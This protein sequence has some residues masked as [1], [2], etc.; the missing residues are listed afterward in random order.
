MKL[1]KSITILFLVIF[2]SQPGIAQVPQAI[3]YQAVARD[4]DGNLIGN[5]TVSLRF[6]VH[7]SIPSGVVVYQEIQTLNTNEFGLFTARIGEGSVITGDFTTIEWGL[8]FK[9]LQVELDT[10]GGSNFTDMGTNQMLSVPYA[11]YANRSRFADSSSFN[12]ILYDKDFMII[13]TSSHDT[14]FRVDTTGV[15]KHKGK[16]FFF[17]G[18]WVFDTLTVVDSVGNP[19]FIIHPDG[20]SWHKGLETFRGGTVTGDSTGSLVQIKPDG[21]IEMRDT[22]GK[23]L[24]R[25]N[26]DGTSFHAGFETFAGGA[27]YGDSTGALVRIKPDGTIE[28]LDTTGNV[29]FKINP[30]GTSY[31]AGLETFAGGASYG[32][33]TG[34][35]VQIKPDGTIEMLDSTGNVLFKVNPDGTSYHAG[36]ETFASGIVVGDT[37]SSF[38]ILLPDGTIAIVD[39]AGNPVFGVGP[40]GSSFHYGIEQF[41]GGI[42]VGESFGTN[43]YLNPDGSIEHIAGNGEL[44][45]K[46]DSAGN[47]FH[48][49]HEIFKGGISVGDTAAQH[50]RIQPDGTIQILDS[51]KVVIHEINPNGTVSGSNNFSDGIIVGDSSSSHLIVQPDG[52]IQLVDS[53]GTVMFKVNPDGTSY[54]DGL[55]S[56][57]SGIAVGDSGYSK[58]RAYSDGS[59]AIVDTNGVPVFWTDGAGN[60]YHKGVEFFETKIIVGASNGEIILEPD[61]FVVRDSAGSIKII[62]NELGDASFDGDVRIEGNTFFGSPDSSFTLIDKYGSI[63]TYDANG[64]LVFRVKPDGTS[65]HKGL[66]TFEGGISVGDPSG[67][68][69]HLNPD[70]GI[71]INDAFNNPVFSVD[72]AGNS[73]HK[74]VEQFDSEIII[75]AAGGKRLRL[76]PGYLFGQDASGTTKFALDEYGGYIEGDLDVGGYS[77]FGAGVSS[78]NISPDGTLSVTDS[79]GNVTFYVLPD[80]S[81]YHKGTELF[82]KEII[83][84]SAGGDKLILRPGIIIG[85]DA[86]GM[87][88]YGIDNL[89]GASFDGDL[90]VFGWS[91]FGGENGTTEIGPDGRIAVYD[92]LG[93]LV[94]QVLPDGSSFHKGLEIFETGITVLPTG[95]ISG[96]GSGIFNLNAD[97][98]SSGTLSDGRLSSAV[99][100][101]NAANTFTLPQT[102]NVPGGTALSCTGPL[103]GEAAVFSGSVVMNGGF[104]G[105]ALQCNSPSGNAGEFNGNVN[106]SGNLSVLGT[107]SKG[108]GTFKID[109]PLDPQNKYLFHSFVES[110]EMINIYNGNIVTDKNGEAIVTLPDYFEAL[111]KD[112]RYQL[113]VIGEFA[114]AIIKEKIKNNTF[115][116]K[117]DKPEIEVSWE[118]TGIRHD[119]YAENNPVIVEQEKPEN[120]KGTLLHSEVKVK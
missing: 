36:L 88:K 40:D 107:V 44:V 30:D 93:Q 57:A 31:H 108:G 7:D 112:F 23:V 86:G 105:S 4:V 96:D 60:S 100:L 8:N 1:L 2:S 106:I 77:K 87:S 39:S 22:T 99:P 65:Y 32:D 68:Q 63:E 120:E 116:I 72:S 64:Q 75:G 101:K 117:T 94:F 70:G 58:F 115:K 16:E 97:N 76:N 82:E 84:G 50:V 83:I 6:T 66:E 9:F 51:N 89:G 34:S 21:N 55:E 15:S 5:K 67:S 73:Y 47:S 20:T 53:N 59:I 38:L 56:Y 19:V 104:L 42:K 3:P 27:A 17:R 29:L 114:Q 95:T 28:M 37:S 111:N 18:I 80:G 24:F 13:S 79:L 11:L 98:I 103:T 14:V 41:Y 69:F 109:H 118:V 92:S 85:Q 62:F 119:P 49:G 54:H 113:T 52:T 26:P 102:I 12:G 81:S 78:T 46:I 48:A 90:D 10:A 33:S 43:I 45:Y 110:P 71:S 35:M 61:R 25:I 91:T 74:G